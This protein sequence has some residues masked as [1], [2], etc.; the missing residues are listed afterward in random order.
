MT[1]SRIV[2]SL[3]LVFQPDASPLDANPHVPPHCHL[4]AELQLTSSCS[5]REQHMTGSRVH[6]VVYD[7]AT[8]VD[9]VNTDGE[10]REF[11]RSAYSRPGSGAAQGDTTWIAATTRRFLLRSD[12]RVGLHHFLIDW[13]SA[14]AGAWPP[15]APP[16]AE[17]DDW[18]SLLDDEDEQAWAAAVE[19]YAATR[20]RSLLFDEGLL[21][22]R[23]WAAGVG[24]RDAIPEADRPLAAAIEAALPIY[25]R[26]WWPAHDARNRAWIESVSPTLAAIE[27][28]MVPRLEAAYGGRWPSE[29]IPIDIVAY[30]N[31]VGAYSIAGRVTISSVDRGTVMPQA[32][33]MIFHESS[34]I[35]PLEGAL[36]AALRDAFQA[37]GGEA[38]D[39]FWHDVIFYTTGEVTRIVLAEHGEPGYEHYGELGV[40]TRGE[41]WS[42]ELP[43][44]E[45]HWRPF[46]SSA[47][48]DEGARHAALETLARELLT[49][50]H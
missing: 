47:S 15:F 19:A 8:V 36:R 6:Q 26:H 37:A 45:R 10:F 14:D 27:E 43:A 22:V 44:L 31:P 4:P 28:E 39:R 21:A 38:P 9:S 35:D 1:L 20:R 11:G 13:A 2:V 34:H 49:G 16:I 5:A 30:A 23:A 25:R 18:R 24:T 48:A 7:G 50:Q 3:V 46:L 33:E 29:R 17:R 42:V 32:V 41:R 12:P 40:Y